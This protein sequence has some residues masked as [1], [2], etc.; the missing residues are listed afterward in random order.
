MGIGKKIRGLGGVVISLGVLSLLNDIASEMILPLL[1]AFIAGLPGGGAVIIGIM[2]GIAESV[3]AFLKLASG[4]LMDKKG[5]GRFMIAIGYTGAVFSR[6]LMGL[7][8]NAFHILGLRIFDRISKGIRTSPRDALIASSCGEQTRG[9]AFGFHRAMDHTGALIGPLISILL[10]SSVFHFSV[11]KV[12]FLAIVPGILSLIPL[13]VA[14]FL[15][16]KKTQSALQAEKKVCDR[17]LMEEEKKKVN[18]GKN[19]YLFI[20]VCFIFTLGNSSDLFLLLRASEC[21]VDKKLLPAIWV[22]LH[23]SKMLFSIPGGAFSDKVG[24]KIPILTGWFIYFVTY[25]IFPYTK[26][27]INFFLLFA[28]YGLYY[29][30]TEGVER[31]FVGD[32]VPSNRRGTA[33]GLYNFAIACGALPSSLIMGFLYGYAGPKI[34]FAICASFSIIA[35]GGLFFVKT[36]L[37]EGGKGT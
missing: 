23:I 7:A 1:P 21:G 14:L 20:T 17:P 30:F 37:R 13:S 6:P 3:S 28:F 12:I 22:V 10:L 11:R 27:E 35:A 5:G 8:S 24:R 2:E 19:F 36:P 9:L 18:L 32:L 26:G 29:A 15:T 16:G 34:A 4:W 33:F 31:A 25:I